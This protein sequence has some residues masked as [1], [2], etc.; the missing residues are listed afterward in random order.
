MRIDHHEPTIDNRTDNVDYND[1]K[2]L[3]KIR[4]TRGQGEALTIPGRGNEAKALKAFE[5]EFFRE[6]TDQHQRVDLFVQSKAGEISRRLAHLDRQVGQLQHRYPLHRPGNTSVKR[7]ERF[8]RAEEAAEKAGEEIKSLARF[9]GAQ[10]LAFVKLLKKYRKWTAS[11]TLESRFRPKVL[12]QPTA[13]SRIDLEPLLTQYS[14]VLAAIRAPFEQDGTP[15]LKESEPS[16]TKPNTANGTSLRP[17]KPREQQNFEA[18]CASGKSNDSI[19]AEIQRA[20]QNRSDVEFDTALATSSIG[21]S[22]GKAS[23]WVH[24]DNLVELHV[25]LLQYTRLRRTRSGSPNPAANG[26]RQNARKGSASG[27]GK[28]LVDGGDDD[29][30]LIICDHLEEFARRRSGAPISDSEETAGRLLEEA[31]ATVRYSPA[32]DAVLAINQSSKES[33]ESNILG[34]SLSVVMKRKAVRHCFGSELSQPGTDHLLRE[35]S[36]KD[37]QDL[38]SIRKWLASHR[39]VQ[40]L[41]QLQTKRTRFVG[42]RNSEKGGTW[43]TIDRDILMRKTPEGFL[44]SKE[45]DLAFSDPESNGFVRFPFAVLEIRSEGSFGT[46]LLRSLDKTH[47]VSGSG[48]TRPRRMTSLMDLDREDQRLL[49]GGPRR[50]NALQ[51]ARHATP[52]LGQST[53]RSSFRSLF[54][55]LHSFPLSIKTFGSCQLQ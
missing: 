6:L 34:A 11:S 31:A 7:L 22:A 42:L 3:I 40:P 19:A 44:A 9:V 13:F 28:C 43:A 29:A 12:D 26:S 35:G 33:L 54:L 47:L 45:G 30:G 50:G 15:K 17:Q 1:L 24:P 49:N 16:G 55:T 38:D 32:G 20:C 41:V 52:L 21:K 53:A 37:G 4:T 10:K 18:A 5:N 2:R 36:A 25:L 48:I 14:Q 27:D 51:A 39:E 23:Y 46:G 8:A